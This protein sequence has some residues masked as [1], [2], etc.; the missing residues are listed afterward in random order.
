MIIGNPQYIELAYIIGMYGYI[1]N[2]NLIT[3]EIDE[4]YEVSELEYIQELNEEILKL[5]GPNKQNISD[6]Q[7]LFVY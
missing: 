1:K 5:F 2:V 6:D 7:K 3:R 4:L